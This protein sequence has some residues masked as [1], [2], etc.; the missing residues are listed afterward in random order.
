MIERD[1]RMEGELLGGAD[2]IGHLLQQ[3]VCL[4]C[5][6]GRLAGCRRLLT[7]RR[8]GTGLGG[9]PMHRSGGCDHGECS[10]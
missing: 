6:N 3:R 5:D 1:V 4:W 8:I 2:V 10:D 9:G 7:G